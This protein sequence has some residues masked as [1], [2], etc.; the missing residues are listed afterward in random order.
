MARHARTLVE[1]R[2]R[3]QRRRST[4]CASAPSASLVAAIT[5]GAMQSALAA[6]RRVFRR[7]VRR[8]PSR[9]GRDAATAV[10]S[11]TPRSR[12][13]GSASSIPQAARSTR[14]RSGHGSAPHGVIVG[15]DG[16]AWVTDGGQ[17]AI[18]RVDPATRQV[19]VWPLPADSGYA[20]LNTATFDQ[21]GRVWFTGQ[22][23]VYGRLDPA[24][25]DVQGLEGAARQRPVRHH[26]HAG[27]DVYYA[28]L[29]GN[30]IARI[31][32]EIG[33]GHG[34]RA[35]DQ[36]AGRAARLVRL[37]GPSVGELLEHRPGRDVRPVDARVARMEAARRRRTRTRCGST[38]RTRCG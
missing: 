7:A 5:L 34:D 6:T 23:G 26:D 37:E 8:R 19:K 30:H 9:R 10:R 22:S 12:P 21:K 38:R 13:A 16:A 24:T 14:C 32:V 4:A 36:G 27:G 25:G 28:S 17:N 33:H 2:R 3:E 18:V 1:A 29:A 35:A 11:S 20:N 15:P 31:D